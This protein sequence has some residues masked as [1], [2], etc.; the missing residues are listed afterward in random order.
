MNLARARRGQPAASGEFTRVCAGAY[1]LHL[2]SE[3]APHADA[4]ARALREVGAAARGGIGNRASG[5]RV[6]L[7]VG[8]ELFIRRARRGGMIRYLLD[9]IYFG[10]APRPLIEL[11]ISTEA[12]RRG[13]PLAQPMG[14]GVR[15]VAPGMYRGFFITRPL[16]G[17][18]LWNFLRTDDDADV[19]A[20]VLARA[21]E[22]IEAMLRAGLGHPDLNLENLFVTTRDESFGVVILDLD[23][24]R[25]GAHA[26][27]PAERRRI[28]TRLM[29]S[30]RKLDPRGRFLDPAV[31][32]MLD[33]AQPVENF[34][35]AQ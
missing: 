14:A 19:R 25:L 6:A 5:F 30:A 31:L 2:N 23:K 15:W 20:H 34:R 21:R 18:T 33:F 29:R 17:M 26:V 24:A 13:V 10:F 1:Q 27:G 7:P 12:I 3:L 28:A 9:D 4:I 22:A 32:S 35:G 8:P 16:A 11:E